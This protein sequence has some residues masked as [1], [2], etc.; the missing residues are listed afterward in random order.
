[1]DQT[2]V[3]KWPRGFREVGTLLK[4]PINFRITGGTLLGTARYRDKSKI[5]PRA[6]NTTLDVNWVEKK[7]LVEI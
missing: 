2:E 6:L 3:W 1:M 4:L 7:E 5:N